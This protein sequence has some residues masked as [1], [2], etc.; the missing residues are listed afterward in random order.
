VG[1]G[2]ETLTKEHTRNTMVK[3]ARRSDVYT[4]R[5]RIYVFVTQSDRVIRV[6]RVIRVF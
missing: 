5:S 6:I 1:L 3:T 4:R 2:S